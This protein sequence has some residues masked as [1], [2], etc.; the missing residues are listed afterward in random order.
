MPFTSGDTNINKEGRP[1]GSPNLI[2]AEL[3]DVF[4]EVKHFTEDCHT[5][6]IENKTPKC[7]SIKSDNSCFQVIRSDGKRPKIRSIMA[8]SSIG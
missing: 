5:R 2:T 3:R 8:T 4:T 7:G 6:S 1:K